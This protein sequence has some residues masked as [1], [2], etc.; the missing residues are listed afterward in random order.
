MCIPPILLPLLQGTHTVQISTGLGLD[1][2]K[3]VDVLSEM[4]SPTCTAVNLYIGGPVQHFIYLEDIV[5]HV[6]GEGEF[7]GAPGMNQYTGL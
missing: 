7:C 3:H 2:E 6:D 5:S 1:V 4:P